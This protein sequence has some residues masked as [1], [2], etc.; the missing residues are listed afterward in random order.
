MRFTWCMYRASRVVAAGAKVTVNSDDP[1]YFG[2]YMNDNIRAVQAA[3]HF[4]AVTWQRIA[5]NSFEASFVDAAQKVAWIKRL[6]AVF[7]V[8]G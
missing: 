7:A 3:F 2:G 1:A 6:D 4:D 8:D 5:R